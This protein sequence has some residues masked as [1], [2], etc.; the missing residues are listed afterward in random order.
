MQLLT[1]FHSVFVNGAIGE[2]QTHDQWIK[3][4][5]L[6]Q[7]SYD[8]VLMVGVVPNVSNCLPPMWGYTIHSRCHDQR[9]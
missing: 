4:P 2:V 5:L 1:G 7:L 8:C 9:P 3:S 6:Y